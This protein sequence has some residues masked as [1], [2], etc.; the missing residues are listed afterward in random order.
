[1]VEAVISILII[2]VMLVAALRTAASS[3][4]GG[5][6][7][8]TRCQGPAL[9]QRLLE[10]ILSRRYAESD[11]TEAIGPE[12][13]ESTRASFDDVDDYDDYTEKPPCDRDGTPLAS[14]SGWERSV[15]VRY[16]DPEDPDVVVR[17]DAGLK[18]I[19]VTAKDP[20]GRTMTLTALR[21]HY[22]AYDL[23]PTTPTECVTWVGVRL[24]VG[25]DPGGQVVGGGRPLNLIPA[26][27]G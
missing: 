25:S 23:E 10:E 21:S 13:G 7:Q 19:E 22:G 8:Q 3:A 17:T 15:V 6:V 9:A 26:E 1:L 20:Q 5:Q 24:Q 16:V 27:G 18:R 14:L 12:V 11:E 4:R 2:S